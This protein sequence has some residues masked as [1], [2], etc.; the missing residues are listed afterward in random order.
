L[1]IS[2]GSTTNA[3]NEPNEEN[4]TMLVADS[5]G[6]NR[7]VFA[8]GLRNTIGFGWHPTTKRFIGWDHG[9]DTLGDDE[10]KEEINELKAGKRYGWPFIYENGKMISHP[11][12]P[13]AYTREDW[14]KMSQNPLLLTHG[15]LGRH[16]NAVL[17]GQAISG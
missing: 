3:A 14:R 5:N 6:R 1:Y 4:A 15:A 8:S 13:P 11:L 17:Y 12:P 10:S 2:V 9:I 16:S 7:K